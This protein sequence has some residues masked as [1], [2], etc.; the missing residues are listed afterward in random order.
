[1]QAVL[2]KQKG[3]YCRLNTIAALSIHDGLQRPLT[4]WSEDKTLGLEEGLVPSQ[5]RA[6]PL[7]SGRPWKCQSEYS[8]GWPGQDR[9]AAGEAE[10]E[11]PQAAARPRGSSRREATR[12]EAGERG[13]AILLITWSPFPDVPGYF[14]FHPPGLFINQKDY[15]RRPQ[16]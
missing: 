10:E 3:P 14:N 2:S 5:T 8:G 6:G 16:E 11:R 4:L 12:G 7:R 1:L 9:E 15:N 13:R